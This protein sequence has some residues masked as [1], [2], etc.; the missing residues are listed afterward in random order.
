MANIEENQQEKLL[1]SAAQGDKQAFGLLYSRYLDEIY[2]FVY[3]KVGS[4]LT[5]EDITEETF[6]KTWESLPKIYKKGTKID[7][8]RAWL[9]RTA[10]NLVIDHYRKKKPA[11]N[12]EH[13]RPSKEPLPE[14]LVLEEEISQN[15]LHSIQKLEPDHQE[16]IILRLINDLSHRETAEIMNISEGNSRVLLFRALKKLKEIL[17]EKEGYHA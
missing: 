2:R 15:L 16:I 14:D 1:V 12:I 6:L 4:R 9:Y 7:N 10:K 3:F 13:T 5:A 8:L 17:V 11:Y